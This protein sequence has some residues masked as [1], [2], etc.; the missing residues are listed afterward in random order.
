MNTINL[1]IRHGAYDDTHHGISL[2]PGSHGPNG[3]SGWPG[4]ALGR[5]VGIGL[6]PRQMFRDL[7]GDGLWMA[8]V[9]DE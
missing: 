5:F 4:S 2:S 3:P 1:P 7:G 8:M 6:D 9:D